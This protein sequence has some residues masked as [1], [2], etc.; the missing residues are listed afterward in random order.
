MRALRLREDSA[1]RRR[2][3]S[4]LSGIGVLVFLVPNAN[5]DQ[6]DSE[7]CADVAGAEV[8]KLVGSAVALAMTI[9]VR[10]GVSGHARSPISKR[11][12]TTLSPQPQSDPRS[13]LNPQWQPETTCRSRSA[14]N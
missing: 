11:C 8:V 6:L 14:S 2:R 3:S 9:Q 4:L 7:L 12:S 5:A 13:A 10:N 1:E